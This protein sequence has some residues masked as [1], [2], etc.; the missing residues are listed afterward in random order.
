MKLF[1]LYSTSDKKNADL[2]T[3]R[4]K[5]QAIFRSEHEFELLPPHFQTDVT[6]AMS[7]T[8]LSRLA[9]TSRLPNT[10]LCFTSSVQLT[11][12]DEL[13]HQTNFYGKEN[14]N[15]KGFSFFKK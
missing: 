5:T 7:A 3:E 4:H 6:L 14:C 12:G 2:S 11:H 8:P 9:V 1:S 15:K 10:G 13:C